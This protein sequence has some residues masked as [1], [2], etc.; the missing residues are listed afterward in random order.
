[1]NNYNKTETDSQTQRRNQWLPVGRGM[2]DGK[3]GLGDKEKKR[4]RWKDILSLREFSQQFI[5]FNGVY[6]EFL[7]QL[8]ELGTR[9]VFMRIQVRSLAFLSGSRI[10]CCYELWCRLQMQLGSCIAVTVAQASAAATIQCL[11]WELPYA[12]DTALKTNKQTN[13]KQINGL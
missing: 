7:L 2:G 1:M 11:A 12:T 4:K 13:N 8:S 6:L 5:T 9:L 10:W 3:T